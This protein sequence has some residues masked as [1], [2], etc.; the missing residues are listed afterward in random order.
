MLFVVRNV[1]IYSWHVVFDAD[2]RL[3]EFSEGLK[4]LNQRL[5]LE[6]DKLKCD[7]D[8]VKQKNEVG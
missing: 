4:M 8:D 1:C 2:A 6:V 7:G 3:I 5:T